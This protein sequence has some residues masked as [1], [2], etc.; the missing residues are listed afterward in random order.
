MYTF[1]YMYRLYCRD[2][3]AHFLDPPVQN[4]PLGPKRFKTVHA[5]PVKD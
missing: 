3:V 5:L 4:P 2:Q 1:V